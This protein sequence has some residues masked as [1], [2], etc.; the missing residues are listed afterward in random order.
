MWAGAHLPFR[1]RSFCSAPVFWGR[2]KTLAHSKFGTLYK[3][4]M[5]NTCSKWATSKTKWPV[6][7]LENAPWTLNLPSFISTPS[8][9]RAADVWRRGFVFELLG[10]RGQRLRWSSKLSGWKRGRRGTKSRC[11]DVLSLTWIDVDFDRW[12]LST[13]LDVITPLNGCGRYQDHRCGL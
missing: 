1:I 7:G 4:Q 12:R 5:N 13:H 9:R 8:D 11:E 10:K 3:K 2:Q 6:G